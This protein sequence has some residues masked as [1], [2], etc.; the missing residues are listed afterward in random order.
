[1]FSQDI[2]PLSL[3]ADSSAFAPSADKRRELVRGVLLRPY[4][5]R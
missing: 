4:F 2:C 1:M 3:L 5:A